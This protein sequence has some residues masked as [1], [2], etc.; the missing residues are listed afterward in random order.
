MW[1]PLIL[2]DRSDNGKLGKEPNTENHVTSATKSLDFVKVTE[3]T[4]SH[5]GPSKEEIQQITDSYTYP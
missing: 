5:R 1:S 2:T 3:V 4:L